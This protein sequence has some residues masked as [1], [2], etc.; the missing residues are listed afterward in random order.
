M[1]NIFCYYEGMNK[2]HKIL[3]VVVGVCLFVVTAMTTNFLL[4]FVSSPGIAPQVDCICPNCIKSP[5]PCPCRDGSSSP[6][7]ERNIY[8][9]ILTGSLAIKLYAFGVAVKLNKSKQLNKK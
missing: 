7:T 2:K 3:M 6:D 8:L 4:G 5:C 1:F 9:S